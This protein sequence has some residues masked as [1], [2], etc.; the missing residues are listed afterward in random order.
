MNNSNRLS[1]SFRVVKCVETHTTRSSSQSSRDGFRKGKLR[2]GVFVVFEIGDVVA[3]PFGHVMAVGAI[4]E[5]GILCF[6]QTNPTATHLYKEEDLRLLSKTK[7]V[8]VEGGQFMD[9][10]RICLERAG[11]IERVRREPKVEDE[12]TKA[13]KGLSRDD[14]KALVAKAQER[15]K[16]ERD[17]KKE[18]FSL[19]GKEE[20]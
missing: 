20:K 10:I 17:S 12:D 5:R 6:Y 11:R 7:G 13:L 19:E 18:S 15:I 4:T 1:D 3:N 8:E 9:T 14:L 2:K 16:G